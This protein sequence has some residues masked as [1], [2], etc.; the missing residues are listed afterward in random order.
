M[1]LNHRFLS[2]ALQIQP[3]IRLL[4]IHSAHT[5]IA[6]FQTTASRQAEATS[7]YEVL[8]L[9]PSAPPSAIKKQF[10][11]LSKTHHPD[12]NLTDPT[13]S[14]RFVKISEAYATLGSP[15]KR[16][17]YDRDHIHIHHTS[18]SSSTTPRGSHSSASTP[19]GGRPASGLSKRRTQFKGPPPSFYKS[20]GW[21][22]QAEKRRAHAQ[23]TAQTTA[24]GGGF[25]PGQAGFNNDVPHFDQAGHYRTQEQQDARRARRVRAHGLSWEDGDSTRTGGKFFVIGVV[26]MV[27]A[28]VPA[29]WREKGKDG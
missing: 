11:E 12:H 23:Q 7:H 16:S 25:S 5:Q 4:Y 19:W 13:A 6:Q 26:V 21:G 10:Y 9:Q 22:D 24:T 1:P 20:G 28:V 3:Q 15:E 29:W 18:P 27:G 17:R 2:T 14:E 8:G